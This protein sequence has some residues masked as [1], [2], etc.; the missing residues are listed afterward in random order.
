MIGDSMMFRVFS[1]GVIVLMSSVVVAEQP[2]ELQKQDSQPVQS[3]V[4][5][6]TLSPQKKSSDNMDGVLVARS[7]CCSHHGGV[8]GCSGNTIMCCD[9]SASPSCRCSDY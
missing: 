3:E 1:I 2:K 5:N 9:G 6:R 8:C 7:G 4:L